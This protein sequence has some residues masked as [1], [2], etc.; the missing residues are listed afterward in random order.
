MEQE[1]WQ[2]ALLGDLTEQ[3]QRPGMQSAQASQPAVPLAAAPAPAPAWQAPVDSRPAQTPPPAYAP[4][5]PGPVD[6]PASVPLVAPDLVP[7]GRPPQRGDSV[8]R[9]AG[10]ALRKLVASST[11]QDVA[12]QSAVARAVQQPVLTGRQIV[13]TS[14]RGGAGKSTVTALLGSAYVH[15][16]HDPVLMVAADP[17]LGTLP[18]RLGVESARWTLGDLARLVNPSMSFQQV[19]GYLVEAPAGG[20]VLP[21]DTGRIGAPLDFPTFQT[22]ITALRRYFAVSVV[23]CETL[24]GELARGAL[25]S[26]HGRVIVAPATFEGVASTRSAL[27]WMATLRRP[28]LPSTVVALVATGPE[29]GVDLARATAH[30]QVGGAGVVAVPYDRH[31][32]SGGVIQ[33]RL[34]GERTREAAAKLAAEALTRAVESQR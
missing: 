23:D 3:A 25:V 13:V 28:V 2:R 24:P 33:S 17:T 34:L 26:A 21:A 5:S 14:I 27:D 32:A 7:I 6:Y 18:L 30:L 15:Y 1:D 19:L 8:S 29:P 31:L 22:V 20:F 12:Q 16:R 9:R 4:A 10:R 11:T